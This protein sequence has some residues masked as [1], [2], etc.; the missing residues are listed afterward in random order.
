V[1]LQAG[2]KTQWRLVQPNQSYASSNDP[3]VHFGLG[4]VARVDQVVVR[5]LEGASEVFG[6]FGIN[7]QYQLRQ[8]QGRTLPR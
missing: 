8:G 7:R 4:A 3:R 5:W 1:R 6:P 2:G